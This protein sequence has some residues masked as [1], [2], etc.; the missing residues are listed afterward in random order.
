MKNCWL[1]TLESIGKPFDDGKRK[2][3]RYSL[4]IFCWAMCVTNIALSLVY[5]D[6]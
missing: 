1:G 3:L 5:M 4:V 6:D 2:R